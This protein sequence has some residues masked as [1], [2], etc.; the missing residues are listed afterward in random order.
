MDRDE[1]TRRLMGVFLEEME[2]HVA[3]WSRELLSLEKAAEPE[4]RDALVRSLFR[5]V[6]SLKGASR[7][8]GLVAVEELFHR[9]EERLAAVRDGREALSLSLIEELLRE[10]DR[11]EEIRRRL[12]RGEQVDALPPLPAPNAGE[13][14]EGELASARLSSV[15]PRPTTEAS[16]PGS[17]AAG[18]RVPAEKLDALLVHA[19]E[20]RL[21]AQQLES[22]LEA[23]QAVRSRVGRIRGR[24]GGDVA[25]V[26]REVEQELGLAAVQLRRQV[27]AISQVAVECERGVRATRMM[28]FE[29]ACE[30]LERV[31]RDTAKAVGKS[32]RMTVAGGDVE[33]DRSVLESLRD[34]LVQLVRNAVVHGIERPADRRA[35][36]KPEEGTVRIAVRVLGTEVAVEVQDDG[37]GLDRA[38]I[39]ERARARGL[40]V[41]RQA[42]DFSRIV[43]VPGFST[44]AH[45]DTSSGRGV[46][47]D[48]VKSKV[49]AIHGSI[50]LDSVEGAGTTVRIVV[51]QT[52]STVQSLLV[53][54][55]GQLFAVPTTLVRT[56][57]RIDPRS[58]QVI[59]GRAT[60]VVD[61]DTHVVTSLH[62]ALG[63]PAPPPPPAGALVPIVVVVS[64][65]GTVALRVDELCAVESLL[66]E[67]L[68]PRI[69]RVPNIAGAASPAAGGLAL[70]LGGEVVRS[71]HSVRGA[72]QRA[73]V[74]T[75]RAAGTLLVVDDS[76]TTRA[77]EKTIL[78]AAGYAVH[79]AN[80]GEE[81]WRVL[82][83]RS[84]DVVVSD[85]EM[86]Y[87][88]GLDLTR[89]IRESP[90]FRDLPVV[91]L[92]ALARDEDRLAGLEA[93]ANAYLVKNAFDQTELLQTIERL[94]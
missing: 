38:T 85:V 72:A 64:P 25:G 46:G 63:L 74:V 82:Q 55:N 59:E 5:T 68:G 56:M 20:V 61:G 11:L 86:P 37:A 30:P 77:L 22:R 12:A 50:D 43:F 18:L 24:V 67:P 57:R 60:V 40:P 8:V 80:D 90:R 33:I 3:S 6:H 94:L 81:A 1:L 36:G 4:A 52:L 92:T 32:A 35:A 65:A 51:P 34:P 78:E 70:V 54:V 31:V 14:S 7:S 19:G 44:A 49:E 66:I 9:L 27:R 28:L 83:S 75:E 41:P 2:E 69:P 10:G 45:V 23:L 76:A 53:R 93:G 73:A 88:S 91:L 17:I 58:I 29:Q 79:L 26:L 47:L 16:V 15:P 87:L 62:E 13:E 39:V 89:R 42:P 71:A 84:V 21:G 48:V